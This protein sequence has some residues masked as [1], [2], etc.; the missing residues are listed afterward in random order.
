MALSTDKW[1]GTSGA[2]W[3][4]SRAN[5]STGFPNSNSNVLI[6]TTAVLTVSYS[7]P[8]NFVVNSLT[9]GK[10]F[11]D[12]SGGNLTIT[13]T[14]HFADGFTQTGGI[15][16]AGG[17]VTVDGTGTLTGGEAEGHTDFVFDGTVALGNYLLGG[18]TSLSNEK[19]TNLTGGI[20]LGDNTGVDATIDNEKSGAFKIAGDFGITQGAAT[21]LFINAGTFEKTGGTGTSFIG[22]DFADPGSIIVAT[23]GTLDFTGPQ[24]S[25]AGAI[26]GIGTFEIGGGNSII[27]RGATITAGTF[28][29][30][31][32]KVTLDENLAFGGDFNLENSTLDLSAVSLTLS[33]TD[34]FAGATIDGN[35]AI[36]TAKGSIT[37]V[38]SFTLGGTDIWENFGTVGEVGNLAIGDGSLNAA[39]FFNEKGATFKFQNDSSIM[40]GAAFGS[41]FLNLGTLEVTAGTGTSQVQAVTTDTGTI[42]VQSGTIEFLGFDNSFAGTISGKGAFEIGGGVNVINHGT[43]IKTASF[44]ITG[45]GAIILGENLS[46][47]GTFNVNVGNGAFL[48]LGGFTLTLTGNDT[49]NG[50]TFDGA[51]ILDT[52][53]GSVSL[54][55]VTLGGTLTWD[56][57]ATIVE[58]NNPLQIGDSSNEAAKFINEKGGE[59]KF[60]TGTGINLGAVPTSSFVNSAGATVTRDGGSGTTQID[61]DFINN[62][63]VIVDTNEI[64]F[65][66]LVSGSGSFTIE[67]GVVLQFDKSVAK[68]SSVD[69]AS[70]TGGELVLQDSPVFGATIHGFG[71]SNTDE[72]CLPDMNFTSLKMSYHSAGKTGGVLTI[73]NGTITASLDFFGKYSLKDFHASA[74][75]TGGTLIVDPAPHA[76]LASGR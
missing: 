52:D 36:V 31:F 47:D 23:A 35:G 76:L 53:R 9:V 30:A 15:L 41:S 40:I 61:V 2:D 55:G 70:A 50:A 43:T 22:V 16:T 39:A 48:N 4:A 60:T 71:G 26:S 56:N 13:T 67:P 25:F 64:E 21:A 24:N 44:D 19:T 37:G 65:E 28:T 57:F 45:D 29:I 33:G 18:S 68:G 59:L 6:A 34:T 8:D 7:G 5:W 66:N 27:A 51:G 3:G 62:G 11:F 1:I 20:T 49:F 69:F 58:L 75:D 12:M 54:N 38:N 42:I 32:S 46:Y 63:R 73:T 74:D 10:D 72:I 17:K 14:A